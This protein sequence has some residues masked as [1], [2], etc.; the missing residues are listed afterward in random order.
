[1]VVVGIVVAVA[2]WWFRCGENV[3][4]GDGDDGGTSS[5]ICKEWFMVGCLNQPH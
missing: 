3:E 5:G 1:M 4:G 2:V